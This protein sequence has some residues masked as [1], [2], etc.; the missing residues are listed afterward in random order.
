[1]AVDSVLLLV[2]DLD[3]DFGREHREVVVGC[4]L[5]V[6]VGEENVGCT[7]VGR[8]VFYELWVVGGDGDAH[9]LCW[10]FDEGEVVWG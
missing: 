10:V 2:E 3:D 1:M 6:E 8:N 7:L 4:V 5:A 9:G